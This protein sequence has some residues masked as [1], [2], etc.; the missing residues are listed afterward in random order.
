MGRESGSICRS[1]P[2]QVVLSAPIRGGCNQR[3]LQQAASESK[4]KAGDTLL[5]LRLQENDPGDALTLPDSDTNDA[6]LCRLS[7]VAGQ[8]VQ[9]TTLDPY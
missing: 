9:R 7:S 6:F 8:E 4:R 2:V 1:N 5:T 3:S